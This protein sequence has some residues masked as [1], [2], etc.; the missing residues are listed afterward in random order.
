MFTQI[1]LFECPELTSLDFF[2]RLHENGNLR[3]KS[4]YRDELLALILDAAA[5]MKKREDQLRLT[6]H[7]L[8]TED[9]ECSE[10]DGGIFERLL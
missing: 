2:V 4:G 1:V 3:E 9:A 8:H 5:R 10:V 7:H 6:T